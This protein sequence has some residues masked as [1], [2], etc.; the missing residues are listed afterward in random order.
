MSIASVVAAQQSPTSPA[1]DTSQTTESGAGGAWAVATLFAFALIVGAYFTFRFGGRWAEVDSALQADSIRAMVRD[2]TLLSPSGSYYPN[3]YTFSAVSSFIIAFIDVDVAT[4]VQ[5]I[6]PLI[7]ATLVI[8][9]WPVFR[10]LTG[11]ERAATLGTLLLFV[12]PEFLFVILRGSHERMLRALLLISVW[13]LIRSCRNIQN[14]KT[15]S[16][17]VFLFYLSVY[18]VIATNS[19]FG[20]S[21]V[22]A[23]G[24]ALIGSWIGYYFGPSLASVSTVIRRRM[25]YI[26][27]F[28]MLLAFLFNAYIYPP[29]GHGT[30]QIPDIFDRLSRLFL[31]TSPDPAQQTIQEY[32]P[33]ATVLNQWIDPKVYFVLSAGTYLLM[34]SSAVIWVRMGLRWLAGSDQAPTLGQWLLWLLYAGFALQGALSI[35]ADRAGALGGN[36]QYRSFPSFVMVAAPLVAYAIEKWRP[37]RIQRSVGAIFLGLLALAAIIKSTNEPVFSNKW[38]FYLPQE[39]AAFHF[40]NETAGRQVYWSDFDERLRAAY[41][42]NEAW[43]ENEMIGRFRPPARTVIVSDVTRLRA[44]RLGQPIPPVGGEQRLYDNGSVQIYRL[45]SQT[46]YQER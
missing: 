27:I 46:P 45:R 7:S 26:P 23:L 8:I 36:L 31:T 17:Y 43:P 20:S 44:A 2:A 16:V 25:L 24:M 13:L 30:S 18:G 34:V 9:A 6:Y 35:V 15:Y 41:T 29:A 39:L 11:S 42:L 1:E 40:A 5:A 19:L 3:G 28:C 4:L 37:T 38:T 10:E 21:Y 12:Q 22:W 14:P 32:D 33:Y